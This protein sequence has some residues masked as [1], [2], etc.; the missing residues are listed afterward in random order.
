MRTLS[1]IRAMRD[2]LCAIRDAPL[3]Q[4][5]GQVIRKMLEALIEL[6]DKT[7]EEQ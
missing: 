3:E 6:M 7:D 5:Y 2:D 4:P 1:E